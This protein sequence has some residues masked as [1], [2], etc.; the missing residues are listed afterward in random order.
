MF[1]NQGSKNGVEH[2]P[3]CSAFVHHF[4]KQLKKFQVVHRGVNSTSEKEIFLN[5]PKIF[6]QYF[7]Y[8]TTTIGPHFFVW[9]NEE[10]R[11]G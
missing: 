3:M 7:V 9:S 10:V 8:F 2:K 5:I 4:V 6:S 1:K 11:G